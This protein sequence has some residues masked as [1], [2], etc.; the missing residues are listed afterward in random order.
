MSIEE[1]RRRKGLS[2]QALADMI[3][4][5]RQRITE[6]EA[7]QDMRVSRAK[8]LADVLGCRLEDVATDIRPEPRR[9]KHKTDN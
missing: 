3:G 1:E 6:Y 8:L 5:S 4:V 7:G 2:Q 9:K